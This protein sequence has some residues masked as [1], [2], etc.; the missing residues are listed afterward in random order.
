MVVDDGGLK[1]TSM[2]QIRNIQESSRM[3]SQA[4]HFEMIQSGQLVLRNWI[5][6]ARK[7]WVA[8]PRQM[9][10]ALAGRPP[11]SVRWVDIST[12]DKQHHNY[13]SRLVARQLKATNMSGTSYFD[14]AP[15]L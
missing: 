3:I 15:P 9:A 13:R 8:V 4:R 10:Y 7:E 14:P 5:Y 1:H 2:G 6:F 11:M 12:R